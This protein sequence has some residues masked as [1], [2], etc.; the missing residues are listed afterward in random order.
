MQKHLT[1]RKFVS[2][3]SAVA[4]AG[5]AGEEAPRAFGQTAGSPAGKRPVILVSGNGAQAAQRAWERMASGANIL[6]ALVAGVNLVE[7]DPEDTS[8]GYGGMPNEDGEVELD[9]AV[10]DGRSGRCGA[11]AGL[12]NIKVPSRIAQLVMERTD[13]VFLVGKGALRFALQHGFKKEDLMTEKSRRLYLQWKENHSD[14]D[15]WLSDSQREGGKQGPLAGTTGTIHM[16]A[17]DAA[18]DLASVTSTSGLS[19]KLAGRVGD[20]PIIG[21]G[22]FTD[23]EVGSAGSTGRGEANI[24]ICGAHTIVEMMRQGKSPTDACLEALRRVV[25]TTTEKRLKTPEGKLK[26]NLVYYALNKRGDYGSASLYGGLK[27]C[28][29]D[30]GGVRSLDC[31]YLLPADR[32]IPASWQL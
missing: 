9:A 1:R 15:N 22:L 29:C 30:A 17:V 16:S 14:R 13:H 4:L 2:A 12:R 3:S 25:R 21:A 10:M 5:L 26:F 32:K 11:V 28:L 6:D 31:A 18:G 7:E 20:S 8:V 23:N 19:Y 24:K 27:F